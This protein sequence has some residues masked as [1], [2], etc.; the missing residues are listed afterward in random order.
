VKMGT[1]ERNFFV[2]TALLLPKPPKEG[3]VYQ[4]WVQIKQAPSET[5]YLNAVCTMQYNLKTPVTK[6]K[7]SCGVT[8]LDTKTGPSDAITGEDKCDAYFSYDP[9]TKFITTIDKQEIAT[10]SYLRSFSSDDPK[11]KTMVLGDIMQFKAGFN[12]FASSDTKT[13][14]AYGSS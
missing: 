9:D 7:N 3:M 13:K 1:K 11:V 2:L 6:L 14:L 12:V 4:T 10:C 8:V 5:Y